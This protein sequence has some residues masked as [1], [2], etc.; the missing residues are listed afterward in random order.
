MPSMCSGLCARGPITATR[1]SFW[2]SS[3]SSLHAWGRPLCSDGTVMVGTA[4]GRHSQRMHLTAHGCHRRDTFHDAP[5]RKEGSAQ[6]MP[7]GLVNIY[8]CNN[9]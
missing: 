4:E 3:G 5:L 9:G 1:V 8:R 6:Q 7:E 2:G